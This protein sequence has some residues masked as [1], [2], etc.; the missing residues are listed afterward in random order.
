MS[1]DEKLECVFVLLFFPSSFA[2]PSVMEISTTSAYLLNAGAQ[3]ACKEENWRR[4]QEGHLGRRVCQRVLMRKITT[5]PSDFACRREA[6]TAGS[7]HQLASLPHRGLP[8][9]PAVV[10]CG[11]A[12]VVVATSGCP[13]SA[14]E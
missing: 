11:G 1:Q 10:C 12:L 3:G 9:P 8:A 2:A 14:I 7:H 13:T 6:R 5:P 4:A